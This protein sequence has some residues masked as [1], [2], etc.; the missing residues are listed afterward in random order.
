LPDK[1]GRIH[2]LLKI[3]TLI[4]SET[5]W[6]AKKLAA[7]C[8][9]SERN[10]F[11]DMQM[12]QGAG[13]P[14]FH[15]EQTNGY[16]V[17]RDFFM[18]PVELTFE[19]SLALIVLAGQ[20][21]DKEQIPFTKA[22]ARV[23]AKVRGQLPDKIR[24]E[25]SDLDHHIELQLARSS[26]ED[27]IKDVYDHVRNSIANRRVLTCSYESL[28]NRETDDSDPELFEFKPYRLYFDQ[29]AWYAIGFHSNRDEVRCLRLSRFS[30]VTPTDKPY[31]IPDDF[32]MDER[33][34][35][36]WRMIKGDTTYKIELHFDKDFAE[37]VADTHW[38]ATQV[39]EWQEDESILFRC[40]VD[41]LDEIVWWVLSMGPHCVVKE[42]PELVSRV[43]Q[44][45][46]E[47][48]SHYDGQD[49]MS[50]K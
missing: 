20:I 7:E 9:T 29:R 40:E 41:G 50:A 13:I 25:L 12:L 14:Y 39:I 11:R 3:L 35:K 1:Y 38:H 26:S 46:G 47:I 42:P 16:R 10:V 32:S 44:L 15:D 37:T 48:V 33:R 43:K 8:G 28:A 19:E 21:G 36:A 18:P 23:V 4:Q 45:A 27:G 6:N 5:G 30:Q 31:Q 49:S 17:R 2:R 22:A 24:R 34:G